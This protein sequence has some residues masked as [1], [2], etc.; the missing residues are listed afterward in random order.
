MTKKRLKRITALVLAV[1]LTVGAVVPTAT[2]ANATGL[3]ADAEAVSD[4]ESQTKMEQEPVLYNETDRPDLEPAEI[5]TAEDIIVAAGYG[6]DV[7]HSFDGISYNDK[8][9]KV[10]YYA[11]QG[12]FDGD[13]PG[14]YSTYYKAEPASGKTPYLICRTISVRE[15][16]TAV[17]ESRESGEDQDSDGEEEPVPGEG[18]KEVT[19]SDATAG[20]NDTMSLLSEGE[21]E[22]F[23]TGDTMMI[24]MASAPVLK[25]AA[26]SSDSMKV[27]CSGYAKYCGH[28]MGI[29]YISQSGDYHNHLVYCLNLNKNTTNGNVSACSTDYPCHL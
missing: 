25:A 14:D 7:E 3:S 6:F 28:S 9:V 26:K 29:K 10:S 2:Y 18:E 21:L 4:G 5:V 17:E 1:V 24:R 20:K 11:G 27:S 23:G 8:A 13:K 19:P 12:S 22:T 15:P 16:E